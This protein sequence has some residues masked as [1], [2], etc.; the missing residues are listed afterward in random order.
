ME[1]SKADLDTL[2][3]DVCI[4]AS[5]DGQEELLCAVLRALRRMLVLRRNIVVQSAT[6]ERELK[7]LDDKL[8]SIKRN[9]WSFDRAL[10]SD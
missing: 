1:P 8:E 9:D 10:N 2:I 5:E 4:F 7:Q 6:M 3:G